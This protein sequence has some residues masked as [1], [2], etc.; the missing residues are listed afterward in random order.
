MLEN[1]EDFTLNGKQIDVE[2][3]KRL[4]Q[5]YEY[6]LSLTHIRKATKIGMQ[7]TLILSIRFPEYDKKKKKNSR[8]HN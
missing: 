7:K 2:T 1:F 8:S 4:S 6:L 5:T 3:E